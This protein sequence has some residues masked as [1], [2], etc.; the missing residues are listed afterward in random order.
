MLVTKLAR[1]YAKALIDLAK[2]Q[3]NVDVIKADMDLIS[4]TL[5]SLK[6]LLLRR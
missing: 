2:E 3:K 6:A 1:V 4:N 5:K